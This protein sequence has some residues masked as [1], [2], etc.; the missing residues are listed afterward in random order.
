MKTLNVQEIFGRSYFETC[1]EYR[2]VIGLAMEGARRG[3]LLDF[4]GM[5]ARSGLGSPI[6]AGYKNY[7]IDNNLILGATVKEKDFYKYDS[8]K[9]YSFL[10]NPNLFEDNGE[11]VY[12]DES[13]G[14][15][16]LGSIYYQVARILD[17]PYFLIQLVSKHWLDRLLGLETR[18]L[19][20]KCSPQLSQTVGSYI[21]IESVRQS[22]S[23]FA[24]IVEIVLDE[25]SNIDLKMSL[26][27]Y[28]AQ[29]LGFNKEYTVD[30]KL[31]LMNQLGFKEGMILVL[32]DRVGINTSNSLG[33]IDMAHIVRIDEIID[34]K[35]YLSL[36]RATRTYEETAKDFEM[37]PQKN[38]HLYYD[39]LDPHDSVY[40]T[41]VVELRECGIGNHF[42]REKHLLDSISTVDKVKKLVSI[43]GNVVEEELSEADAI[44]YTLMQ[45]DAPVDS[46]LFRDF[47][48]GVGEGFWDKYKGKDIESPV[49]F[50]SEDCLS[51]P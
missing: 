3:I 50:V 23:P 38:R 19:Y 47:Y 17:M 32:Y 18:K 7:L 51:Q 37:I 45:N 43:D 24:E 9:D 49:D 33:R 41:T 2:L 44:Y 46:K 35:L 27:Q 48:F 4:D 1:S 14:L 30:E 22:F 21:D 39:L 36:L 10:D 26:F 16:T 15:N 8:S 6:Y 28:D 40:D 13:Y 42:F 5:M 25:S 29:N 12:W 31:S 20:I 34:G 11:Y